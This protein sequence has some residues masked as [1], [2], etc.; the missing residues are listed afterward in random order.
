M[1]V[2]AARIKLLGLECNSITEAQ[3]KLNPDGDKEINLVKLLAQHDQL[4][5]AWKRGRFLRTLRGLAA[6]GTEKAVA[7]TRLGFENPAGL[8]DLFVND[9]EAADIWHNS[10]QDA[11]IKMQFSLYRLAEKGNHQAIKA[12]KEII[13]AEHVKQTNGA[14]FHRVTHKQML[15]LLNINKTVLYYWRTTCGLKTNDDGTYDLAVF[16]VWYKQYYEGL[17]AG[18]K[19]EASHASDPLKSAKAEKLE[20]EIQRQRGQLLNRDE[21]LAGLLA[22]HQVLITWA[23]HRPADLGRLCQGQKADRIEKLIRK[24]IDELRNNLC[25]VP[26][27]LQLP[28]GIEKEF[29]ELMKKLEK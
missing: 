27:E 18:K 16:L 3:V 23:S 13:K 14:N 5:E 25:N 2:S 1:P 17:A 6:T 4:Q 28:P 12:M 26:A 29:I 24:S 9:L 8:D 19:K 7:A 22:R 21:V 15:E 10:Q 20:M 11:F